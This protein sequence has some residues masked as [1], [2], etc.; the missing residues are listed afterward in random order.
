VSKLS[1]CMNG[2]YFWSSDMVLIDNASRECIN[3][4]IEYLIENKEFES[5]F[6]RYPDVGTDDDSYTLKGS[7]LI[8]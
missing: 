8:N 5:I 3:E 1:E 2:T 6:S 4:V 7:F